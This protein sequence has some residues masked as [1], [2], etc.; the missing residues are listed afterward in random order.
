M[1]Y[2]TLGR[3]TVREE[4]MHSKTAADKAAVR[5]GPSPNYAASTSALFGLYD[6]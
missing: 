3:N 1:I 4:D 5:N 6:S 2:L